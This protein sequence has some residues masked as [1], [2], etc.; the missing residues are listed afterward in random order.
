MHHLLRQSSFS[1]CYK[2]GHWF[3]VLGGL[4]R[5][6]PDI[7]LKMQAGI[8]DDVVHY[9]SQDCFQEASSYGLF[10][11]ISID[12]VEM[13][14]VNVLLK[15]TCNFVTREFWRRH[16]SLSLYITCYNKA[17]TQQEERDT[18]RSSSDVIKLEMREWYVFVTRVTFAMAFANLSILFSLFPISSANT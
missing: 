1:K 11:N 3:V 10:D 7:E 8:V 12:S 16:A 4:E 13:G 5:S 2:M 17:I 18:V 6:K 15:A 14:S 9:I